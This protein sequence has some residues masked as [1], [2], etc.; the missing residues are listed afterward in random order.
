[1]S[2]EEVD[3]TIVVV[4]WNARDLLASCL[5]SVYAAVSG[6][7]FEVIVVDNGSTDGST[8]MVRDQFRQV[9]L[10]ENQ[11]NEGFAVANNQAIRASRGRYV[12][13]LNSDT[14]VRQGAL[15]AMV[16]FADRHPEV[17]I[18][19]C[20]LLNADGSLQP[21]WARFPTFWSELRGRNVRRWRSLADEPAYEVDWVGG[22]CLLAR[23]EA[24]DQVGLLDEGYFMYSEEMD[25][26]YRMVQ[27][28]WRVCYLAAAEVT[29]LGG[30]SSKRASDALAVALYRSKLRFFQK[31]YGASQAWLLRI[32]LTASFA[33]KGVVSAGLYLLSGRRWEKGRRVIVRQRYLLRG[34]GLGKAIEEV[35]V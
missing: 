19:G 14:L 8:A 9:Q 33:F 6:P 34:V 22:A 20:K 23:R 29:H 28:G 5:R 15:E 18:V 11:Q 3:C 21:S 25:W 35:E 16:S 13:L 7:H 26:C 31:H 27:R 2:V 10:I 12:L 30:G 32:A 17:G 4:N 1:M 24:I